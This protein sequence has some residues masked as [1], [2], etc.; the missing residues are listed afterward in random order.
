MPLQKLQFRPGVN[1]ET[2]SYTNEGGWFDCEKIRF[3]SGV[4]EKI[5]GWTKNSPNTFLGT[6]R[7]LHSWVDLDGDLRT[8]LGTHL[9]YYIKEGQTY[10]DV[11]PVRSTTSAG[12]VTF[13]AT[14]GSST[15]TATDSSHGAV[16]GDFVTFSGAATLGGLITADVLNQEYQIVSVP[17]ANTFTFTAKDTSDAEVTANSSDSGNG[18]SSVVGTY[19]I[20]IGLDSTVLG[21]GWGAGTWGRGTW[22]SAVSLSDITKVLR[23]WSHDNF[24]ED[25]LIN[26]RDGNIFYWDTSAN[27]DSYARAIALSTVSGAVSAPTVAKQVL[28]SDRDRH[29]IVFGCDPEDNEGTQDPLLIRFSDQETVTTWNSTATNTAGSL[30]LGSGS[31]IISAVETR[32]QILVFTDVSLHAMQFLGPP[33]TYGINL[34]SE[35]TTIMGPLAAKAVDDLVFWMGIEDFYVY[36]GRVQKLPCSVKAYVFND[37][38]I[39]QKE[40]VF[41]ALN[42]AFDEIWWFYP[43]ADSETIDRYVVYNYVQKIWYYGTMARTAWLDRGIT[44]NPIAAGTDNFLYDHENGLDDGSTSP[45]S[46][47]TSYI[48]SSQ[49]DIGDG[50]GFVFIK[51]LVPDVTFDGSSSTAP[52]ASF[53]LKARSFPGGAYDNSDANSITQSTKASTTTV[54]QF[55]NQVH[56]RLRGRSFALRVGSD[57]TEV[58]WRLGSPRVDIRQD[59]RR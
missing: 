39:L 12:D 41:G 15:I 32:Q 57:E 43:S 23:L 42:S 7:A 29:V 56:V 37:F 11:T 26:V 24:G 55:T 52:T 44:N 34:I 36:D 51:R 21:T 5:G 16:V 49:I 40:K 45:A 25:L 1:R 46:A 4:P 6:C 2:T 50:D 48:E 9:K 31:E 10:Y 3:R 20:N 8:G 30:R 18:G 14:N 35:N 54:E 13:S 27:G 22:N 59:G 17:T 47:I 58:K 33:F 53:T 28:V 19:Q 38:N